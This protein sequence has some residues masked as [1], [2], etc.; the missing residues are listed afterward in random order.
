MREKSVC[1]NTYARSM[2]ELCC[3]S[4]FAKNYENTV[5]AHGFGNKRN[6]PSGYEGP[7][8]SKKTF[9]AF[10]LIRTDFLFLHM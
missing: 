5:K 3:C 4:L 8:P 6:I 7:S 2:R 9:N 1:E 10:R